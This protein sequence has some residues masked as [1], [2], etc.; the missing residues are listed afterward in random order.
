MNT[1][2]PQEIEVENNAEEQ[3]AAMRSRRE[4][5]EKDI[6]EQIAAVTKAQAEF[7][8]SVV[9]GYTPESLDAARRNK[10]RAEERLETLRAAA[11][12]LDQ[13][14]KNLQAS[15]SAND[16]ERLKAQHSILLREWGDTL[17]SA[18]VLIQ[19]IY[20]DKLSGVLDKIEG[21]E[22]R[23]NKVESEIHRIKSPV[24]GRYETESANRYAKSSGR[25]AQVL[26]A[27]QR[28][29]AGLSFSVSWHAETGGGMGGI[30]M[31]E[32]KLKES[33]KERPAKDRSPGAAL[34]E[35]SFRPEQIN[36]AT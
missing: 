10:A 32:V 17:D 6:E 8:A 16:Y 27:L 11:P 14:I 28:M 3:I 19:E 35:M 22:S 4:I 1:T 12:I 5:L 31:D 33:L 9:G 29:S 2:K 25:G 34:R 36:S 15:K 26:R 30:P 7:S 23:A 18:D 20:R 21:L 13:E 24:S